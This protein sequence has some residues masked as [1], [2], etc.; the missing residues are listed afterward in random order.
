MKREDIEK[1]IGGYATNTLTPEERRTLF[2]AALED[3]ALFDAIAREEALKEALEDPRVRRQLEQSLEQPAAGWP[4]RLMEWIRTPRAWT[5]GGALAATAALAVLIVHVVPR[6]QEQFEL[7]KG[8]PAAAQPPSAPA[9]S[10]DAGRA[11]NAPAPPHL[12]PPPLDMLAAK[13]E[14]K[15]EESALNKAKAD[16]ASPASSAYT[17]FGERANLRRR[18]TDN[19]L[20]APIVAAPNAEAPQH[21]AAGPAVAGALSP[22]AANGVAPASAGV[23]GPAMR[24]QL[25]PKLQEQDKDKRLDQSKMA[26]QRVGGEGVGGKETARAAAPPPPGLPSYQTSQNAVAPQPPASSE[27]VAAV[28]RELPLTADEK[29]LR[30]EMGFARKPAT[31]P[32]PVRYSL[33]GGDVVAELG[34]VSS[35]ASPGKGGKLKVALET[36]RAGYLYVLSGQ[37]LL[38]ST[39]ARVGKRYIVSPRPQDRKLTVILSSVPQPQAAA[40]RRLGAAGAPTADSERIRSEVEI[41]LT[42]K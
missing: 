13:P 40:T 28:G 22:S 9:P 8:V 30:N 12:V 14:E 10:R 35:K 42:T 7:A 34:A 24:V 33:L 15:R 38:F 2:E 39:H 19:T 3:Q 31:E 29:Q 25:E 21:K 1:L 18:I 41:D 11:L 16:V 26:L 36:T 27:S 6:P 4:A 5:M 17:R 37:D 32:S 23:V 20:P